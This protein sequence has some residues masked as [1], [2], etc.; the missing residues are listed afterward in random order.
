M[1]MLA[2]RS[3]LISGY[4]KAFLSIKDL[5][6]GQGRELLPARLCSVHLA[7]RRIWIFQ[8]SP[9]KLLS[10]ANDALFWISGFGISSFLIDISTWNFNYE[11]LLLTSICVLS[12][13]CIFSL[14]GWGTWELIAGFKPLLCYSLGVQTWSYLTSGDLNYTICIMG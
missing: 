9:V 13:M 2:L 14:Q 4:V 6:S 1:Q 11:H 3:V 10:H 5:Y 7:N 8:R 12:S